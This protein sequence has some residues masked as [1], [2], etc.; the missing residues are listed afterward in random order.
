MKKN[1]A[2]VALVFGVSAFIAA[3][4]RPPTAAVQPAQ[5]GGDSFVA[6]GNYELHYN[7][8]RTDQLSAAIA[9]SYG[10]ERSKNKVMLNV[11]VLRKESGAAGKPVD[12]EVSVTAHNLNGQVKGLQL[13]RIA[14]GEA[15]YYIGD[16]GISGSEVLVFEISALPSGEKNPI[17]AKLNREF[18]SD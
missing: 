4:D 12:A 14:E 5:T 7:A 16:V 8:L 10:I 15:I 11:A 18:F 17:T 6:S 3:C 1:H 9:Q 13:R 2:L